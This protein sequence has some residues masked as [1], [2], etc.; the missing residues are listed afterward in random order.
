MS[1]RM[2][3]S[4]HKDRVRFRKDAAAAQV[5]AALLDVPPLEQVDRSPEGLWQSVLKVEGAR[6][7]GFG[8]RFEFDQQIRVAALGVE[9]LAAGGGAKD[10][11]P[12]D[13]KA[14]TQL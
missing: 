12:A 3:S 14:L 9:V 8:A 10:L 5:V 4:R 13:V 1:S 2:A 11:Q 6:E 7:V